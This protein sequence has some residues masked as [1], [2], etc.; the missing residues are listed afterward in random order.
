MYLFKSVSLL[1]YEGGKGGG[2]GQGHVS[3][4]INWSIHN[5]GEIRLLFHVS[6]KKSHCL[7]QPYVTC[8]KSYV[9]STALSMFLSSLCFLFCAQQKENRARTQR[10]MIVML[11]S[12]NIVNYCLK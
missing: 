9:R 6:R 1:L 11:R 12:R 7:T 5:S 3:R 2:G 4:K 10:G 8:H